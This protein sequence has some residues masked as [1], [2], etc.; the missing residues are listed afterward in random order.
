MLHTSS[1]SSA[2][3]GPSP[4]PEACGAHDEICQQAQC[5]WKRR[6]HAFSKSSRVQI[7]PAPL[8]RIVA[9]ACDMAFSRSMSFTNSTSPGIDVH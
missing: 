9:F 2:F 5:L 7:P 6:M 3:F 8:T 1:S 4:E